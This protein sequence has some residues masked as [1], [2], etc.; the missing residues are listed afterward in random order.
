[1]IAFFNLKP[2]AGAG[3]ANREQVKDIV[4][5]NI[6]WISQKEQDLKL[7]LLESI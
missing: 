6:K 2:N 3:E 4:K 5:S 7:N 1:M